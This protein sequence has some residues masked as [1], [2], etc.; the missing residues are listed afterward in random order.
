MNIMSLNGILTITVSMYVY[1][2]NNYRGMVH[3]KFI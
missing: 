1:K 3:L 2:E